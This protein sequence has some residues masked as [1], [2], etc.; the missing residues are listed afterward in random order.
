MPSVTYSYSSQ[1]IAPWTVSTKTPAY[2]AV[3]QPY[4]HSPVYGHVYQP[5]PSRSESITTGG[6]SYSIPS[7]APSVSSY[8][9]SE[10]NSPVDALGYMGERLGR[11]MDPTPLDRSLA[12]QAQRSIA[13]WIVSYVSTN[14]VTRSGELN[15]KT[16]ELQ[17]LQALAQSRLKSARR[18]FA[19]GI[20]AARDV[21]RD[22]EWTQRR[23]G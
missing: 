22:L 15:A 13:L 14:A 11:T 2:T 6:S 12:M 10:S 9:G 1:P 3:S 16:R 20:Q 23:V 17:A 4:Q 7:R 21:Q 5:P 8:S 19:D 18:N